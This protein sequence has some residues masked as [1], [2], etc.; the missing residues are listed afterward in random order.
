MNVLL[1]EVNIAI[2]SPLSTKVKSIYIAHFLTYNNILVKDLN[3]LSN[4][5]WQSELLQSVWEK[6]SKLQIL[7]TLVWE[8]EKICDFNVNAANECQLL[9]KNNLNIWKWMAFAFIYDIYIAI[10]ILI[11]WH[12]QSKTFYLNMEFHILLSL[13]T[14]FTSEN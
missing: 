10:E 3:V 14:Y 7:S 6:G 9:M 4:D 2:Y 12:Q 5:P 13:Y 1:T 11:C 8:L